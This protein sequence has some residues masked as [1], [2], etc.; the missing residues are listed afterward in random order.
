MKTALITL[1]RPITRSL[2]ATLIFAALTAIFAQAAVRLPFT[3][4]PMTLQVLGVVLSGLFLG[5]RMGML[6]QLEYLAAGL[7]GAPVFAH[8]SSGPAAICGPSGG[9]IPGF[10]LGAFTTGFFYERSRGD[11][12]SAFTAGMAG[13]AAIYICGAGW[14]AIWLSADGWGAE[15]FGALLLGIAPFIGVDTVKV[16]LASMI[17][18]G[19]RRWKS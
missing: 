9:Y 13:T 16:T 15:R 10:V 19:F 5:S 3:P 12:V 2:G 14:L 8:F 6:S 7:A 18:A 1:D 11:F 4:I 17:A